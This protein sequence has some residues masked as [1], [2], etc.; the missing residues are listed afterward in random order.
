MNFINVCRVLRLACTNAK[1]TRKCLCVI[2]L[3]QKNDNEVI[4]NLSYG[5][6]EDCV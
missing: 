3:E 6:T 5:R 4:V 2:F 1:E